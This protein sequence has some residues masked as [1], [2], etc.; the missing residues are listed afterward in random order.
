MKLGLTWEKLAMATEGKLSSSNPHE[1]F[2]NFI[3]NSRLTAQGSAFWALKGKTHDG[4][5]FQGN[6]KGD[7][8]RKRKNLRQRGKLKQP[9]RTPVFTA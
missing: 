3:T 2:D 9:V 4:H 1:N 7:F 8:F 5:K 6:D